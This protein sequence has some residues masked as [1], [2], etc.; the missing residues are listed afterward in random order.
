MHVAGPTRSPVTM[1]A[2]SDVPVQ[3]PGGMIGVLPYLLDVV[4][5]LVS[6]YALTAAGLSPF[7]SL[8]IGGALTGVTSIVNTIRRGKIDKLGALVI[9][10]LGLGIALTLTTRDPRLVLARGSLYVAL[11]GIWILANVF[12]SR[13]VTVDVTKTFAAKNGKNA[14]IAFEWLAANSKRFMRIQ[15]S[16]SA[17]W[18][19]M[20]LAYAAVRVVIIFSVSIS[21]AVWLTELPA[22]SPSGSA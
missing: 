8:V 6:Y 1:S 4:I 16:I 14:I 3:P 10:E 7:W 12:T 13:P 15:R 21:H 11:A 17:V 18:G 5:P 22:S 20:F 2:S 9:V 19:G